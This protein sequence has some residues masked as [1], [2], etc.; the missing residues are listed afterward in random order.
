[1]R[2]DKINTQILASQLHILNSYYFFSSLEMSS[3]DGI[4][5]HSLSH[6]LYLCQMNSSLV[7]LVVLVGLVSLV[8]LVGFIGLVCFV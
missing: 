1:M 8:G 2:A 3:I 5:S 4:F 7:S 6:S